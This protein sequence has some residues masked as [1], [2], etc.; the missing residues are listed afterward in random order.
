[1]WIKH[2]ADNTTGPKPQNENPE[3]IHPGST[4]GIVHGIFRM[5]GEV[6]AGILF[7]GSLVLWLVFHWVF[8][9]I[10]FP[11]IVVVFCWLRR[12]GRKAFVL[13]VFLSFVLSACA[14]Y[15]LSKSGQAPG[16]P[17]NRQSPPAPDGET[18]T[19]QPPELL[20][21]CKMV[22]FQTGTTY[23]GAPII[24]TN[25]NCWKAGYIDG[26][27]SNNRL[28]ATV[29]IPAPSH[30]R[31]YSDFRYAT[32]TGPSPSFKLCGNKTDRPIPPDWDMNWD[33][34][35]VEIVDGRCVPVCQV[36]YRR[37]DVVV[38]YGEFGTG[39]GPDV[40]CFPK[41]GNSSS[42]DYIDP[43]NLALRPIFKYPASSHLGLRVE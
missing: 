8:L 6:G 10:L 36:F 7:L 34:N 9:L 19:W 1:M 38:V 23:F 18:I 32:P 27:I 40:H 33:S 12:L 15:A 29:T 26:F 37:P 2:H 24:G 22:F 16:Q 21:G 13:W 20:P 35:A 42:G 25:V 3:I 31:F 11:V 30:R 14:Y 43:T 41:E 28:Y 4:L 5:I 39:N 17:I